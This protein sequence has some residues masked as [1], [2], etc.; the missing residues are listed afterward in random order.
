[1]PSD[2]SLLST[3]FLL[4]PSISGMNS[5]HVY[6]LPRPQNS[7]MERIWRA[8]RIP[9]PMTLR[10][11]GAHSWDKRSQNLQ[12][13]PSRTRPDKANIPT[14]HS[15][16][17]RRK[18]RNKVENSR[19]EKLGRKKVRNE[20]RETSWV[21]TE[22]EM[23]DACSIGHTWWC[24]WLGPGKWSNIP[25][26]TMGKAHKLCYLSLNVW[27]L[28]IC[29]GQALHG[30]LIL[31]APGKS[32]SWYPE[33]SFGEI[34]TGI[35]KDSVWCCLGWR[36]GGTGLSTWCCLSVSKCYLFSKLPF[37]S[38]PSLRS[39]HPFTLL[40]WFSEATF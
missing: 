32:D 26:M 28:S 19:Q 12:S 10:I 35:H 14:A 1:M 6:C 31:S 7:P 40:N 21:L 39:A 27:I 37:M 5:P 38:L 9:G 33:C 11:L 16:A 17:G 29:M 13:R 8:W 36:D 2:S 22:A 4:P 30:D 18:W 24:R 23:P 34:G 25:D 15:R 3:T 20:A